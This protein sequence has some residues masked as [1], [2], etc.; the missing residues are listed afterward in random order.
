LK[1]KIYLVRHA[2]VYNPNHIYYV[3]LPRFLLSKTGYF[4]AE[5]LRRYFSTKNI[6]KIY[7]S[8]LLRARKTAQIIAGRK[9]PISTSKKIIE[10]NYKKWQGLKAS[11]RPYVELRRF[12][13]NP[14]KCELGETLPFV[15]ERMVKKVMDI[16]KTHRGKEVLIVSHADPILTVKFYFEGKDIKGI[17][18]AILKNASITSLIFDKDLK[19]E[20]VSYQEI[21]PAKLDGV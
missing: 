10:A 15:Q 1:T 16:A 3:W 17:N 18:D 6:S 13:S 20:Q 12:I 19:C 14:K 21:V 8:P 5:E 7:T 9:I 4:Q 2:E 11:D